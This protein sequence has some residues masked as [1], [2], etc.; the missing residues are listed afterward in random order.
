M[1][2]K[3][4]EQVAQE[5]L[6]RAEHGLAKYSVTVQRTDL[7]SLEWVQHAKEEAMDLVVYL[8]RVKQRLSCPLTE[9]DFAL[10]LTLLDEVLGL[11]YEPEPIYQETLK[12]FSDWV[13]STKPDY[14]K[15][16]LG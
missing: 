2:S 13:L 14:D 1:M 16:N 3:V 5:I 4:E 7:T 6:D 9:D 8:E 11:G 10:I 12:K 15:T